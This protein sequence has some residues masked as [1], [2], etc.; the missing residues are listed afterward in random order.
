MD[1]HLWGLLALARVARK[2]DSHLSPKHMHE[3]ARWWVVI[4]STLISHVDI[5][6]LVADGI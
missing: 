5:A 2:S 6:S 3:F 4:A 1:S